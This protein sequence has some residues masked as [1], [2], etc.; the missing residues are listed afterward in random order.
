MSN[1]KGLFPACYRADYAQ[2]VRWNLV[3]LKKTKSTLKKAKPASS[4]FVT[5][6]T[7][8]KAKGFPQEKH[9]FSPLSTDVRQGNQVIHAEKSKSQHMAKPLNGSFLRNSRFA[10]R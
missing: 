2:K 9:C 8:K 3:T 7:L 10:L 4:R 6:S 1:K 5:T